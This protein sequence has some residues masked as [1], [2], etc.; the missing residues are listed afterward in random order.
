MI[1]R[2]RAAGVVLEKPRKL[3]LKILTSD[4][5]PISALELLNIR[6]EHLRNKSSAEFTEISLFVHEIIHVRSSLMKFE[7]IE[8]DLIPGDDSNRLF[9]STA[10]S[11]GSAARI[12]LIAAQCSGPI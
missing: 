1:Q 6:I 4:D 2:A 8:V 11:I 10:A 5:V 3:Q 12:R 9:R 7:R